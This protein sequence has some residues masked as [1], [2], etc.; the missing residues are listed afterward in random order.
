[1]L[2]FLV[3]KPAL[4]RHRIGVAGLRWHVGGRTF[5]VARSCD[6]AV[7]MGTGQADTGIS[8]PGFEGRT[9]WGDDPSTQVPAVRRWCDGTH[10]HR[11]R[12]RSIITVFSANASHSERIARALCPTVW[13][14]WKVCVRGAGRQDSPE[15]GCPTSAR[16]WVQGRICCRFGLSGRPRRRSPVLSGEQEGPRVP[17]VDTVTQE[18]DCPDRGTT[19]GGVIPHPAASRRETR[20]QVS[21][22]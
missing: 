2:T 6:S 18:A 10:P 21:A 13:C 14:C 8:G 9:T 20:P 11:P 19:G 22:G 15:R 16:R 17:R 5:K 4:A 1:M 12:P 3:G 7:S